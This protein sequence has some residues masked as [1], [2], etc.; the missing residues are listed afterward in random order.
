MNSLNKSVFAAVHGA[1][2]GAVLGVLQRLCWQAAVPPV[3]RD[4][5]WVA[6]TDQRHHHIASLV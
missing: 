3:G 5:Q 2:S 6:S 1:D 4:G